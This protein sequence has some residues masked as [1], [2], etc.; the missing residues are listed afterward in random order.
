MQLAGCSTRSLIV[1]YFLH[2]RRNN[3]EKAKLKDDVTPDDGEENY[4]KYISLGNPN[5]SV[6]Q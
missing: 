4:T 5:A 3:F 6:V 1:G 2:P